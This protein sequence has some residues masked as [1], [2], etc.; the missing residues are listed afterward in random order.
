MLSSE[1]LSRE[2]ILGGRMQR[3]IGGSKRP[4]RTS[5]EISS[6]EVLSG[7]VLSWNLVYTVDSG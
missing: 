6:G 2:G 3:E 1:V 5:G 7:E 4:I